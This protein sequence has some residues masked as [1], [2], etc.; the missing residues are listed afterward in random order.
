M[1]DAEVKA[2]LDQGVSR[3]RVKALFIELVK[4]PS[5]QTS[6]LEEEPLLKAFIRSAIEP[7]LR[8]MGIEDI[9]YDPLGNLLS[10][11]GAGT[12]DRSLMIVAHAMNQPPS[13]MKNPYGGE[14]V[15]GA[16][17]GLPV[18]GNSYSHDVCVSV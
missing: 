8:A 13:S 17:F 11:C 9:R 4:V 5:P 16:Q 2:L 15:D 12:S 1:S 3:E 6:L 10:T 18:V 7:R 14:V